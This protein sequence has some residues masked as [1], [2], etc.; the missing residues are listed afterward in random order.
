MNIF[1]II[2][3]HLLIINQACTPITVSSAVSG[4]GVINDRRNTGSIVDDN[5]L[6]F[7]AYQ[8]IKKDRTSW[9]KSN[10]T[11]NSYNNV[12]LVT[13]QSPNKEYISFITNE[14][15]KL[16][17]VK[18]VHN[19]TEVGKPSSFSSQANDTWITAKINLGMIKTKGIDPTRIKIITENGS[20]FLMGLVKKSEAN[21]ASK[22]ASKI[23][24]VEK[25]VEIFEFI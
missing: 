24:G 15:A 14:I 12:I 4:A 10:I 16:E 19:V 25:V 5:T 8:L 3:L 9:L 18:Y 7:K 2:F 17:N 23:S 11:I 1:K 6:T 20:V 21:L 22:V 13:G